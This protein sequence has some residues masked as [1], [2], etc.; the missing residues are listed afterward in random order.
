MS[1]PMMAISTRSVK[2]A[3]R[4]YLR[5]CYTPHRTKYVVNDIVN[6]GS[7]IYGYPL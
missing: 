3:L 5:T 1:V 6:K 2:I 4:S 7:V